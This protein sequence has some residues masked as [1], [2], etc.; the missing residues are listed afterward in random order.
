[1]RRDCLKLWVLNGGDGAA[2]WHNTRSGGP[3]CAHGLV[4]G[5]WEA[6]A[7][8]VGKRLKV[9]KCAMKTHVSGACRRASLT[10]RRGA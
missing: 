8:H 7:K 10:V 4:E 3:G 1:M 6:R 5:F 9:M 2:V